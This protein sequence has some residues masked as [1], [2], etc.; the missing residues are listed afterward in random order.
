MLVIMVVLAFIVG[1]LYAMCMERSPPLSIS[2]YRTIIK[3]K[4]NSNY[5]PHVINVREFLESDSVMEYGGGSGKIQDLVANYTKQCMVEKGPLRLL[6]DPSKINYE[7]T[8][9]GPDNEKIHIDSF[10]CSQT[11]SIKLEKIN[12]VNLSFKS[13][14]DVV[15][16]NCMIENLLII[17]ARSITI[18][19]SIVGSLRFNPGHSFGD[20]VCNN[21]IICKIEQAATGSI[22]GAV[23]LTSTRIFYDLANFQHKDIQQYRNFRENCSA[24]KDVT[25]ERELHSVV[26]ELEH[27]F[28]K[29]W[30][31]V[32]GVLYKMF[33]DYGRSYIRPIIYSFLMGVVVTAGVFIFDEATLTIDCNSKTLHGWTSE[34]C[35]SDLYKSVVLGFSAFINPIGLFD[36]YAAVVSASAITK[37]ITL[38]QGIL[39]IILLS[40]SIAALRKRFKIQN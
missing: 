10:D 32:A 21:S 2:K 4:G 37:L 15:I 24:L 34:L 14:I 31:W 3:E 20:L 16:S 26:L 5:K 7:L 33:S 22:V 40:L 29:G 6:L 12:A 9:T 30:N 39:T 19:D 25:T 27:H 1:A 13:H 17:S 23:S 38:A 28:E 35:E 36:K 8:L 18:K 11:N